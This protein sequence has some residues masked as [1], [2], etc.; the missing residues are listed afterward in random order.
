MLALNRQRVPEILFIPLQQEPT[1]RGVSAVRLPQVVVGGP[2]LRVLGNWTMPHYL[3]NNDDSRVDA[4]CSHR[5]RIN[6]KVL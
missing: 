3:T 2:C 5:A 1:S 4:S 6:E